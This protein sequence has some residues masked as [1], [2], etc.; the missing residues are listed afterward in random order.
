MAERGTSTFV[1][2]GMVGNNPGRLEWKSY[3]PTVVYESPSDS[4]WARPSIP[5]QWTSRMVMDKLRLSD[6]YIVGSTRA[7]WNAECKEAYR[8]ACHRWRRWSMRKTRKTLQQTVLC[9]DIIGEII[10]LT[11]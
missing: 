3:G 2:M 4:N 11:F 5:P 7:K 6:V 10:K 8:D 9:D 1:H